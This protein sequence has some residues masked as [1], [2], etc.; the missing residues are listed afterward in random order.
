VI[1]RLNQSVAYALE[2]NRVMLQASGYSMLGGTPAQMADTIKRELET[3]TPLL[4]KI[5]KE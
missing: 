1:Q 4:A 5:M 2:Q 3:L